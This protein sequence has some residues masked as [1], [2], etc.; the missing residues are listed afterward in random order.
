MSIR[1]GIHVV[2]GLCLAAGCVERAPELSPAD[3][4]RLG[5]FVSQEAPEVEHELEVQFE[6][7]VTFLGYDVSAEQI[8][9]GQPVTIT[10][11]WHA[12]QDLED[13][14][15]MFTH[16]ADSDDESRLNQ[17]GVGV[18]RE[19]YQPGRWSAGDYIR[20][21]QEVSLPDDWDSDR[22]TFYLGLW[23]GPH[24]LA[25][26]SGPSDG[27]NRIRA[28]S[29]PVAAT[30][31]APDTNRPSTPPPPSLRGAR[32]DG[33]LTI[34]GE[35]NEEAWNQASATRPFVNTLSGNPGEFQATA[36]VLWNDEALYVGF[37]VADDF[38]ANDLDERDAHLWE[39]D[40][41]EIMV[42][43][44]GDGRNYFE[45]QVSPTGQIFDTRYDAR[46]QPQP[47]GH[48]DWNA[49]I[50]AAAHVEGTANDG[51]ADEGYS[52]E[53]AIPWSAF[54]VGE[55]P[56]AAPS[57]NQAWRLNFYVMDKRQG[58]G[59]RSVG[60][61]PTLTNDFHLP[62][63][64]GRVIFGAALGAPAQPAGEEAAEGAEE[65]AAAPPAGNRVIPLPPGAQEAL[66]N[67]LRNN[68]QD[69]RRPAQI[70][71]AAVENLRQRQAAERAAAQAAQE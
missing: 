9:P 60:W 50:E 20:D 30:R 33:E 10:W 57:A 64:F 11:Y 5:E 25:I 70:D 59:M 61:S 14:W 48:M 52:V 13:G 15:Q 56:A 22:A 43:P 66:R 3:R 69:P 18:V 53:I 26:T 41:V 32:L 1:N 44:D 51:D 68:L 49:D 54:A 38:I 37:D 58:D 35:L 21:V 71:P 46:R 16:V 29:L 36:R 2:M 65:A 6:N 42:D 63:R 67:S 24:R 27:E 17:D 47:F 7:G 31:V 62:T 55:P 4:E 28:L 23:N 40:A 19:L 39:Q 45:I 8:Q 34:D 12:E